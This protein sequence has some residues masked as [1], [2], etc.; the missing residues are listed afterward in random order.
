MVLYRSVLVKDVY[1]NAIISNV[2]TAFKNVV[3]MLIK[4]KDITSCKLML[5]RQDRVIV[6]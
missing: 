4:D 6:D 5:F 3:S 1:I 2:L